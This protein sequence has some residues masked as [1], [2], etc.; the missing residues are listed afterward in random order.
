MTVKIWTRDEINEML[1][2]N[3]KAV[4]RAIVRLFELQNADEQRHGTTN[5]QNGRGFCSS[6]A[7]AGTR[8]A[9]WIQGMDNKNVV[10]YAPKSLNNPKARNIFYR[11]CAPNGTVMD[12]ARKIALKHSKQLVEIANAGNEEKL[13]APKPIR[14]PKLSKAQKDEL[15]RQTRERLGAD[16]ETTEEEVF[17]INP[18]AVKEVK[19]SLE[20]QPGTLAATAR[21]M[22]SMDESEFDWDAWKEQMKEERL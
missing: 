15:N 8:F 10:R 13:S 1:R 22:A 17:G 7:R 20:P 21:L 5:V 3:D 12:R 2:S 19:L 6:D 4:E 16:W 14:M 11:Y 9:R 18:A